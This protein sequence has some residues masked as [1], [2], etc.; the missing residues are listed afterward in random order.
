MESL[1]WTMAL[2]RTKALGR[3][4]IGR[5]IGCIIGRII[6]C[7]IGRVIGRI[8]GGIIGGFVGRFI[9]R[10][11]IWASTVEEA[12]GSSPRVAMD[13]AI[14]VHRARM[15]LFSFWTKQMRLV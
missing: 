15:M 3:I 4:V 10:I 2:G 11:L 5:T 12:N 6:G 9:G 8:V 1:G 13:R 7:I 14:K